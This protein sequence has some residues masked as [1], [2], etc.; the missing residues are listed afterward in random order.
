MKK[1]FASLMLFAALATVA[2]AQATYPSMVEGK[3]YSQNGI[4]VRF[5]RSTLPGY[6]YLEISINNQTLLQNP[7][8]AV[9]VSQG[10]F[11]QTTL[12]FVFVNPSTSTGQAVAIVPD[13]GL[14][15]QQMRVDPVAPGGAYLREQ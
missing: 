1:F 8:F 11:H 13:K 6:V 14:P 2:S 12:V 3:T 9:S 5:S 7:M 4:G 10:G 15:V